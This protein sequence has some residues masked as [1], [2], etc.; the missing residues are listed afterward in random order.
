MKYFVL[1]TLFIE[2]FSFGC[3]QKTESKVSIND[4]IVN[5]E[6]NSSSGDVDEIRNL[7]RLALCW[8]DSQKSMDLLPAVTD[9]ND[10]IYIGFDFNIHKL[11]LEKLKETDLFADEFIDNYN[12][13]I[14]TLDKK[15][16]NKEYD[17]WLAGELQ[18]FNFSNDINPWCYCQELPYDKPNPWSL[19][20]ISIINLDKFKGELTW[21]WGKTEWRDIQYDFNV[22]KEDG[23]WKISYMKG[24]DYEESIEQL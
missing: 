18:P 2:M 12:Q 7:I 17:D 21:T 19:V 5:I 8:A 6:S 11:N 16:K 22:T 9:N 20:E 23:K 13:V 10:S 15:L 4:S 3:T 14:I 1:L 24:F